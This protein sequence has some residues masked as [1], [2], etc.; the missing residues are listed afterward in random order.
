MRSGNVIA[1][2]ESGPAYVKEKAVAF[3]LTLTP[4]ELQTLDARYPPPSR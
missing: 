4:Q 1:I 2:P 3:S